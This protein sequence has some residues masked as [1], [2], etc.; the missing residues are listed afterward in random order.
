MP[1]RTKKNDAFHDR[2][3]VKVTFNDPT[4]F[5]TRFSDDDDPVECVAV[6][7]LTELSKQKVRLAWLYDMETYR[8]QVCM[9]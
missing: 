4:Q 2:K 1:K 6:G 3:L 5:D 9:V 8:R 7:W